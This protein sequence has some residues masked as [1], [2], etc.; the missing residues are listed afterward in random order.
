MP[1]TFS[2][3]Y[4]NAADSNFSTYAFIF[5]FVQQT[6]GSYRRFREVHTERAYAEADVRSMLAAA[7]FGVEAVYDCFTLQPPN[8]RSLRHMYVA[9]RPI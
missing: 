7:G 9:R 3:A 2:L 4:L 5:D 6:D 1:E 8:E